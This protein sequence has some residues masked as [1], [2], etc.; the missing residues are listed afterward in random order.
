MF[1]GSFAIDDTATFYVN[2]HTPSTGAAVDADADPGYRLYEDE[3]G[4]PILTG[5]MA[6][7]D[8]ANTVGFYS[9]QITLSAANGF[10][11]GKSYC[12][13]IT[14]VVGGVT[15]TALRFLQMG[16]KV[17]LRMLGGVVQSATDLKDFA[18]DGYD[19]ATNKVEG[20]K[21]ADTLTTYTGNTVQTGDSFARIGV[22]GAGLTNID[23]PNQ[24]MDIVGNIIGSLA[25][26]VGSVVGAVGSVTGAVGSVTAP[27]T[28]G[29][30]TDKTGYALSAAGN[31]LVWDEVMEGTT[32]ARE[33]LR[34]ANSANGGK[35]SGAATAN[36]LIRNIGDS[37]NR[38]D[39]TVDASG[40][41]TAVV[42][43]L[44]P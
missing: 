25:G 30:V 38:V 9:E 4:T 3:T 43:D 23:L 42:L 17:D 6:K 33:S 27:V 8:D 44:T 22:A 31:D 26:S 10:E 21:L 12:V 11:L 32:T 37:K 39:A 41:R 13:R 18:D 29:T 14:I 24:T 2:S 36:I 15:G 5:S 1:L 7:L 40:N 16:S 28:A 19:P 20:V 35:L 34:L